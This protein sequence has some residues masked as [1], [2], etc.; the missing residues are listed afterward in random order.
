MGDYAKC[1]WCG[2]TFK[3]KGVNRFIS[4]NTL[5][6]A[7]REKYCSKKCQMEAEGSRN[8]GG[9]SS[10]GG[11]GTTIINKESALKGLFNT[12]R[13]ENDYWEDE[14]EHR[15]EMEEKAAL[16]NKISD[17]ANI[18]FGSDSDEIMNQLNN[19]LSIASTRPERKVRKAIIE[20]L[21]FGIMKL[22]S[23]GIEG[24]EFDYFNEKFAKFK[25][26]GRL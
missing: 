13:T 24:A 22:R 17:I 11:G 9:Q 21:D 20:K 19:L 14:H 3:K 12:E 2:D 1:K 10:G 15:R 16:E 4:K 5:G 23:S 25:K 7:G 18:Q 8:G 6:I 26:K